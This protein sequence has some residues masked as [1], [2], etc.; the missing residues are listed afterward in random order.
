MATFNRQRVFNKAYRGLKAQGFKRAVRVWTNTYTGE[1]E[2]SCQYRAEDGKK[3]AIGH[4][5]PDSKYDRGFEGGSA[6]ASG[7]CKVMG[8]KYMSDDA[9]WATDLQRAHDEGLTP[10]EMQQRLTEFA[11]KHNLTVPKR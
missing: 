2:F 10:A 11:N 5:I 4:C 3:C 8:Y 1:Q 9:R 6:T 7:I